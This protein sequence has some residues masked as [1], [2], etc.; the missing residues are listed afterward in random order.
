M[1]YLNDWH[2]SIRVIIF[3]MSLYSLYKLVQ[4][5]RLSGGEWNTKTNDYWF[6]MLM[7]VLAG[8]ALT[9]Q[10]VLLDRPFTPA[11]VFLT[12]AILTTAKGLHRKGSWGD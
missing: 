10:G 9:V 7:W 12:A 3:V 2:D 4:A 11:F 5:R 1:G 6:A 8:H